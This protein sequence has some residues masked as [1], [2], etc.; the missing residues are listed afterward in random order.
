MGVPSL[1][2]FAQILSENPPLR[3]VWL[4]ALSGYWQGLAGAREFIEEFIFFPEIKSGEKKVLA[5]FE[6]DFS[7]DSNAL[8]LEWHGDFYNCWLSDL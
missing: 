5:V 3:T 6:S 8:A 7:T 1:L 4:V 2:E